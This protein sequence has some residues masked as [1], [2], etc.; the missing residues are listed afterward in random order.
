MQH[1]TRQTSLLAGVG[2]V[3][4]TS[5]RHRVLGWGWW[6]EAP[7]PIQ[8]KRRLWEEVAPELNSTQH[9]NADDGL[10]MNSGSGTREPDL[11]SG[12]CYFE[13]MSLD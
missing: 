8:E 12:L 5:K 9:R 11:E 7:G 3:I 4:W 2:S 10:V 6:V 13:P 1:W